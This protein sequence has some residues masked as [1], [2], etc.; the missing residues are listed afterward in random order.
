LTGASQ[1]NRFPR[2]VPILGNSQR[3]DG[4]AMFGQE[5]KK[6]KGGTA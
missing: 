6:A 4:G 1:S 3:L 5:V 2:I